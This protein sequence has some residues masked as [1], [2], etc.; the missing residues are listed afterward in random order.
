MRRPRK[1]FKNPKTP[2]NL[3]RLKEERKILTQYGLR[4]KK[5]LRIAQEIL[6]NFR[7]RARDL[8]AVGN[9]EEEK[10]LIEKMKKLGLLTKKEPTLDDIL[11]LNVTDILERRLQTIVF[12]KGMANSIKHARQLV[13]HGHISIDGRRIKFPSYLVTVDEEKKIDWYKPVNQGG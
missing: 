11:E 1:K 4:R 10:V 12:K 5:E 13:T 7:R 8:I 9:K 6:R 2:W 3:R